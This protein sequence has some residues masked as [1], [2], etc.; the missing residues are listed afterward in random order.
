MHFVT[1]GRVGAEQPAGHIYKSHSGMGEGMERR[2]SKS[3]T[4][5]LFVGEHAA[6]ACP[7]CGTAAA[8]NHVRATRI[9]RLGRVGV[10]VRGPRNHRGTCPLVLTQFR[11]PPT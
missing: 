5:T 4:A 2:C 10:G 7:W 6:S 8:S 3:Q 9:P 1:A 11:P